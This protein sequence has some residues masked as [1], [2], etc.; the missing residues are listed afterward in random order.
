MFDTRIMYY[1]HKRILCLCHIH[2]NYPTVKN[3]KKKNSFHCKEIIWQWKFH[4]VDFSVRT[5]SNLN[6]V[7]YSI[8]ST[9]TIFIEIK[10]TN[11]Y[12]VG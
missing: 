11:I 10:Y 2:L 12:Q 5:M 8:C 6:V 3:M 4:C 1:R 7:I 9:H